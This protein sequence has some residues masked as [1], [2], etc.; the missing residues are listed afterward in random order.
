MNYEVIFDVA[1]GGFRNWTFPAFGLIFVAVGIFCLK[2]RKSLPYMFPGQIGPEDGIKL[3]IFVLTFSVLWMVFTFTSTWRDYSVLRNALKDGNV[4]V[5][6]GRVENF[7]SVPH[8]T[9]RFSV[10]GASF[11]YSNYGV[12]AGFNNTNSSGGPI[13][14]GMWVR[15]AHL[16]NSIA[17]LEIARQDAGEKAQCHR[18]SR[19]TNRRLV[20]PQE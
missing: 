2:N 8:K 3:G 1:E 9:E 10:C 19:L 18:A 14:D 13:R 11:S 12:T 4:A 6:E 20:R 7:V 15:I 16:G 5:V 17:R